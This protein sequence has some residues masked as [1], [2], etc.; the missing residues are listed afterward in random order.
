MT[1]RQFLPAL[2]LCLA[3]VG[4]APMRPAAN[5]ADLHGDIPSQTLAQDAVVKLGEIFPPAKTQLYFTRTAD[6]AFGHAFVTGLREKGYAV[7]EATGDPTGVQS[8]HNGLPVAYIIDPIVG[9]TDY[10]LS[11]MI[12]GGVLSRAY[13]I[14]QGGSVDGGAWT[15]RE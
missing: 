1:M 13:S 4:C 9:G 2:L 15:Y 14:Y 8:Q 10:R 12:G 11:L 3:M 6:D 5:V 7:V